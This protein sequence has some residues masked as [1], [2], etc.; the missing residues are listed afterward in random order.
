MRNRVVAAV[1][2]AVVAVAVGCG[3]GVEDYPDMGTVT[4]TVTLDG[5]PLAN[6]AV[7]FVP[8]GATRLSSASTDSDG[9]YE[10]VYSVSKNGAK[11][12]EH[13]VRISTY[14][15]AGPDDDGR[16]GQG[17]C[18]DRSEQIQQPDDIDRHS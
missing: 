14:C 10:L 7:T 3:D 18:R 13:K 4:G 9:Y 11:T 5:K 15:D 1:S 17:C 6:A 12:G 2:I 16:V 8:Q